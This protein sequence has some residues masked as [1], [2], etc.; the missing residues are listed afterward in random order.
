MHVA[1]K[2]MFCGGSSPEGLTAMA[3][4]ENI[5]LTSLLGKT[6]LLQGKINI[7]LFEELLLGRKI[8][9]S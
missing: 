4:I 7:I 6:F 3:L 1:S 5:Y 2:I 9:C 8:K